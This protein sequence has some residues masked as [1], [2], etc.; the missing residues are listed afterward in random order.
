M[1][2]TRVALFVLATLLCVG[3][4]IPEEEYQ[5]DVDALKRQI[6]A[7][8]DDQQELRETKDAELEA[9]KKRHQE[10]YTQLE[11]E[12]TRC[13]DALDK[14]GKEKGALTGD[15]RAA[16]EQLDAA[17]ALA[18]KQRA[19]ID[20][21]VSSLK[22]MVSAGKLKVV[23]REGRLLVE[24]SESL[25]FASGQSGLKT[26]GKEA[27]AELAPLL[28]QVGREFQVV[29]H[30]DNVGSEPGNWKLSALRANSV[31]AVMIES[32]YPA[33]DI[34]AA[35][36]GPHHPVASNDTPEGRALNRRV[37]I[38]LVP[39]LDDLKVPVS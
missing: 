20:G 28:A 8:E 26:E 16:V 19:T 33:S 37:E 11:G 21:I 10:A 36:F 14:V 17:K 1:L 12:R 31:V 24:I 34:S 32:G 15:L 3:C 9:T 2:P 23:R 29:G 13:L 6:S 25:L 7:L 27:I 39:N 22:S 35:G 38:V 30:T 5:R 4:G 18:A